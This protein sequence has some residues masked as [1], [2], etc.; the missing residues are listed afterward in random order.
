MKSQSDE[1]KR[2][3]FTGKWKRIPQDLSI[4]KNI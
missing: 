4:F 3:L 1:K 2:N